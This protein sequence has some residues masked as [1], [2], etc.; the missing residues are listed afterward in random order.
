[1]PIHEFWT[2]LMPQFQNQQWVYIFLDITFILCFFKAI[3]YIPDYLL[4][5]NSGGRKW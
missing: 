3:F 4:N 2:N 5:L 1:M